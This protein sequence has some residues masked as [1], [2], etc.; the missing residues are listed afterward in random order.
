MFKQIK[1]VSIPVRDQD[2]ALE[3]WTQKIG[4]QIATDQ[5]MGPGQR[6]IELKLPGA[7]TGLV[8]FTPEGH[9]DRIGTFQPLSFTVQNLEKVHQA[10]TAKG[11]EF[12]QA[13]KK[14]PWG[15][16]ALFK[17]SE[18]NLFNVSEG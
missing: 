5:P 12:T 1:F 3:F 13:P 17:D 18:G 11:V 7:Q 14:N 16:N 4:L 10:L 15:S 2:R 6:W 8:L 9:E